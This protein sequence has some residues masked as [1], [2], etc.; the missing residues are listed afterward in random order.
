[1]AL[2]VMLY[3]PESTDILLRGELGVVKF[4]VRMA[5]DKAWETLG[6]FACEVFANAGRWFLLIFGSQSPPSARV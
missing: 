6:D 4:Q 3:W 2:F 5:G 1:M